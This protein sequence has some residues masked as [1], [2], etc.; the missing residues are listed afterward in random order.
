MFSEMSLD[1]GERH[2]NSSRAAPSTGPVAA[3]ASDSAGSRHQHLAYDSAAPPAGSVAMSSSERRNPPPTIQQPRLPVL[4]PSLPPSL[5]FPS[6]SSSVPAASV[7]SIA[8]SVVSPPSAAHVSEAAAAVRPASRTQ[9]VISLVEEPGSTTTSVP[10]E[11]GREVGGDVS[12]EQQPTPAPIPISTTPGVMDRVATARIVE[13]EQ[14]LQQ[15]SAENAQR[16]GQF[17][18]VASLARADAVSALL[19]LQG[20]SLR[21]L[22]SAEALDILSPIS[23]SFFNGLSGALDLITEQ[24]ESEDKADRDARDRRARTKRQL[25]VLRDEVAKRRRDMSTG[26]TLPAENQAPSTNNS[27]S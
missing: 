22:S 12:R 19:L 21:G 2:S 7:A 5:A 1:R 3:V 20:K 15:Q 6:F 26:A 23:E 18:S 27:Q 11:P 8:A 13:L 17:I 16:I 24:V 14:E 25:G 4:T 10:V 9:T